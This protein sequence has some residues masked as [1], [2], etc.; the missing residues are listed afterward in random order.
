MVLECG[1]IPRAGGTDAARL[2]ALLRANSYL[3]P[4]AESAPGGEEDPRRIREVFRRES[5]QGLPAPLPGEKI[6]CGLRA[7]P[8]RAVG[9]ALFRTEGRAPEDFDG[10]VLVAPFL[11]GTDLVTEAK[12]ASVGGHWRPLPALRVL[13]QARNES[14]DFTTIGH[15]SIF[16]MHPEVQYTYNDWIFSAGYSKYERDNQTAFGSSTWLLKAT[17]R[18]F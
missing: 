2:A 5:Y 6:V 11:P 14:R 9:R 15:E 4:G 16:S 18:F 10:A 3:A 7:S 12:I 1:K 17:R 8:G 13:F